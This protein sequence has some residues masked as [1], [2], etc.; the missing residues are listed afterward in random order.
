V[1]SYGPVRGH[2]PSYYG[3]SGP[4]RLPSLEHSEATLKLGESTNAMERRLLVSSPLQIAV[5]V[6]LG[7]AL[8]GVFY[9]IN[10]LSRE[11]AKRRAERGSKKRPMDA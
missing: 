5:L 4:G 11:T 1:A 6:L 2:P 10:V 9:I 7:A 3:R 8:W